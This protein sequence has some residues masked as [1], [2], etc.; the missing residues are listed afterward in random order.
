MQLGFIGLGH[1]GK[2]IAGRL[3]ES[4]HR[5][6]L[7]NRTA[8]RAEGMRAKMAP[9]PGSVAEETEI[10]FLCLFDSRAVH[11]ILSEEDGLLSGDISGRVVVDLTTNHFRE[12][13]RFHELCE[14]A[15]AVYLETP[16]LGSVGPASKGALTVLVSGSEAGYQA[17]RP[18]LQDIAE[19]IFYLE[20]PGLATK[21]K[22]INNLVLGTF[23][24]SIAEAVSVGEAIGM[25]KE[26]ILEILSVGGGDS[27]VLDAKKAKLIEEDFS[28]HFSNALIY[29]DLHCLQD[30]AYEEEV[31]VFT[32]SVV[33][34]I[35][36]RAFRKGIAD[37]D[38]SS[39]YKLFKED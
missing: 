1:L 10:V 6:T 3:I 29:K 22:L 12:V 9:T 32:G 14:A 8:S 28:T 33:K 16:V 2:A 36:S 20:T 18:V 37:K 31:P 34:E 13:M 30:L 7:W 27:L 11:G 24:A 21:M 25:K 4:G 15:G 38:F 26:A 19:H 35:Y 23:M 5:L 39:V 17:V